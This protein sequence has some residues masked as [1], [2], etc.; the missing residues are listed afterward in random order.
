MAYQVEPL[1][2]AYNALEP[3]IDEETMHLHHDKHY[4]AYVNNLN[5]AIE[6]H[7]EFGKMTPEELVKGI[8]TVPEDIRTAVRNNGGGAVN[9]AMFWKIMAPNAGGQPTGAIANVISQLGGF[10]EF[11]QKFNAAGATRFGSGWAWL[12]K[13]AAG[14]YDIISSA[15][16]DSPFMEG[17]F[18]IFGNDV[19]EHAY[20]LKYQNRRPDY[21][22]AWWNV[23]NWNEINKRL[24]EAGG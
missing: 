7:P 20:Y 1:P 21:L 22:K 12:V 9:H 15:N 4:T 5:A 6:K 14:S 2:Y 17:N 10:E 18:P 8:T 19:W 23:V 11:Q 3:Y 13:T 24:Q 16:Q